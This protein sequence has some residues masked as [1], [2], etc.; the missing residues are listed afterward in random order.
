MRSLF[1]PFAGFLLFISFFVQCN[2]PDK[3]NEEPR[4]PLIPIPEKM[5]PEEGSFGLTKDTRVLVQSEDPEWMFIAEYFCELINPA[6][7]FGLKPEIGDSGAPP[8][9]ILFLADKTVDGKEAYHLNILPGKIEISAGLPNGAFYAVQSLRQ[10]L[11]ETI[12]NK[13]LV[14]N[15][16]SIPAVYIE[17]SPRFGWRGMHLDVSRHFLPM[18]FLKKYIDHLARYKINIFHIHL[19]DD[20]GWRV[21]IDQYPN[22]TKT[23]AWRAD[24]MGQPWWE[25]SPQGEGE[26]A[27]YGGF[28]SKKDLKELVAYAK[29]RY[30]EILP[31]IDV[32]GHSRS[33]IAS[34]PELG[35]TEQVFKVATGGLASDNTLNPGKESVYEFMEAVISEMSELF[36]FEYF[37]IGGDECNKSNWRT[38]PECLQK[39][40]EEG[41]SSVEEL[42]SYFIGRMEKIL[43]KYDKKLMGWDEI[44]E[45]GLAPNARVM[46]W[47]GMNGGIEAAKHGH[48]VVMSPN[49]FTYFDLYQGDPEFEPEAYSRLYLSTV[50]QFDPIPKDLDPAKEKHILGGHGCLWSEFVPTGSHAEYM[51]FPRLFALSESVWSSRE[52]KNW[53]EFLPRMEKELK[54]LDIAGINYAKSAYQVKIKM[55]LDTIKNDL[56]VEMENETKTHKIVYTTDGTVPGPGSSR[57]T[58]PIR[59]SQSTVIK[60]ATIKDGKL[61]SPISQKDVD[62]N[63]ATGRKVQMQYPCAKQYQGGGSWPWLMGLKEPGI[64]GMDIGR[65]FM[66]LISMRL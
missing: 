1:V 65:D 66:A 29:S 2:L 12:D 16:W 35:C 42:Q 36:P 20:Q 43:D 44:L 9:S 7:G 23:G 37:H 25:R 41:L 11:P 60:A 61:F 63:L 45:G 4:F 39:M 13:D 57:Y 15:K 34:Y 40:K 10:L 31:E 56:L 19:T 8:N 21:E 30:V 22:L 27:G 53:D 48:D 18:E 50:Y 17:D 33:I 6:T 58:D 5:I 38:N 24:R 54:R 49:T 32:P 62:I 28:Y 26:K 51:L 52:N 14:D 3:Q 55:K 47:R 64:T 46:S 59:I